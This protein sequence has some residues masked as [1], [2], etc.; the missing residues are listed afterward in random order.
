MSLPESTASASDYIVP[1]KDIIPSIASGMSP[2]SEC[3]LKRCSA[4]ERME[5]DA[6]TPVDYVLF[7]ADNKICCVQNEKNECT[8]RSLAFQVSASLRRDWLGID[9]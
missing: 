5:E 7:G 9:S 6:G 8:P 3:M 4:M 1:T 2:T